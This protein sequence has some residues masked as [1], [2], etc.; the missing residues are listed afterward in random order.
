MMGKENQAREESE[1]DLS[2]HPATGYPLPQRRTPEPPACRV[3]RALSCP[4]TCVAVRKLQGLKC[5]FLSCHCAG[6][7]L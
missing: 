3:L 7:G 4:G 5:A 1:E 2:L 6:G